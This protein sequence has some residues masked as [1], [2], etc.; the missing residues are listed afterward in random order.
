MGMD[1]VPTDVHARA[2]VQLGRKK[3][4]VLAKAIARAAGFEGAS[5]L[6]QY[7]K[8]VGKLKK[9]GAVPDDVEEY[10]IYPA[11]VLAEF[12]LVGDHKVKSSTELGSCS[13]SS[14]G[15]SNPSKRSPSPSV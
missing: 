4:F 10:H 3:W 5:A 7:R 11:D 8:W 12:Y 14:V 2:L 6:A 15:F 9:N 13:D 1:E